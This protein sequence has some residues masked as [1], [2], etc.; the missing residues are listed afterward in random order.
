MMNSIL[1]EENGPVGILTLS[2]PKQLNALNQQVLEE[3]DETI[4]GVARSK[5]TR[6]LIITGSG[7]K[8]F[9]AGADIAE[10]AAMNEEQAC[11]FSSFGSSVFGKIES[12]PMPVIAAVNGLALGGGCELTL[13]C[14]LSIAAEHA[15]FSQ[16]EVALGII[17]GWG[18]T[19]RLARRVGAS[20]AKRLIFTGDRVKAP[21]ALAIGLVDQVVAGAALMETA[22]ELSR[23]IA[24][25]PRCALAAAKTAIN[26]GC[27]YGLDLGLEAETD[28]FRTC[29][30]SDEQKQAL[31]AFLESRKK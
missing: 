19:Q 17:P 2:R 4:D 9:V 8:A 11:A 28:L 7:E 30:S 31:R 26:Q 6:C 27:L 16:P 24:A 5:T 10:M 23:K 29:F 3:L 15:V 21:E 22:L 18:G 25:Q 14:D 20:R 1:F 12:L 13:C